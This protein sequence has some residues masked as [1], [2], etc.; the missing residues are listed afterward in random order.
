VLALSWDRRHGIT[1]AIFDPLVHDAEAAQQ[2]A[3]L[4]SA[5]DFEEMPMA[6][7]ID[8]VTPAL[9]NHRRLHGGLPPGVR[10]FAD[11]FSI[12]PAPDDPSL[13]IVEVQA[14]QRRPG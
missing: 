11:L 8:L 12:A 1:R 3:Q 2:T 6:F 5:L 9:W 7:A 4:P 13:A 10:R 14:P